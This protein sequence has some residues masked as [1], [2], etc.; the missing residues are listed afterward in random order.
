MSGGHFNYSQYRI[1][2]IIE[3]LEIAITRSEK[4]VLYN[5]PYEFNDAT[6]L[7]FKKGLEIL[8]NAFVYS[9]R[10]DW[11]LSGD[12]SE[13]SFHQRLKEELNLIKKET[14]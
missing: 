9:Q 4:P 14:K 3:E 11:L 10:I 6:V 13:E 1:Q 5:Y 12:D 8:K 7:E 2:D